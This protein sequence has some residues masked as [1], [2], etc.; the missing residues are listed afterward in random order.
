MTK[1]SLKARAWQV[2]TIFWEG[3]PGTLRNQLNPAFLQA[4]IQHSALLPTGPTVQSQLGL[5]ATG[6]H[7]LS[8]DT[9]ATSLAYIHTEPIC[10]YGL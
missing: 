4:Q 3:N 6:E 7:W 10:L 5:G 8:M 9:D 2:F 1:P